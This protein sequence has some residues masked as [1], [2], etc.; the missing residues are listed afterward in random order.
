MGSR[1]LS[2]ETYPRACRQFAFLGWFRGI[3]VSGEEK[4]IKPYSRIFERLIGRFD[5]DPHAA[6]FINDV[7]R[8][9]CHSQGDGVSKA[10]GRVF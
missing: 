3:L 10:R 2:A 7:A 4:V 1:T 5:I 8:P 6:V 9:C